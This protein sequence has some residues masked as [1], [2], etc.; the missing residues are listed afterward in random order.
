MTIRKAILATS[1][2][3]VAA[4]PIAAQE[5][6]LSHW[7]PAMHPLQRTGMEPW[8]ESIR[9]ATEGRVTIAIYPAQQLG[10]AVDHYDMARDGIADIVLINPGYQP[11]RFPV[12]SAGEL[13]FLIANAKGGSR[14]LHEWYLQYAGQEMG[15]TFPC[16]IMLHDPGTIHAMEGPLQ[17]PADVR[18][19]NVRPAHATLARM[20][21][22][23]GGASVQ[24]SPAEQSDL[25]S[26]GAADITA[27]PWGSLFTFGIEDIVT[28]HL[29]IPLYP[30]TFAFVINTAALEGLDPADQQVMRDHCTPEWSEKVASP[31]ADHEAGGRD[32]IIAMEGHTLYVP[33]EAEMAE[34]RA[35]AEPLTEEWKANVTAKGVDAEAAY[36]SFV[37]TL[38]RYGALAE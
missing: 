36:A 32:Q 24:V 35:V 14:A 31:W 25:L 28:H 18:G 27:S 15:D 23:L 7:V 3:C 5:L 12:L 4:Q 16:M 29:D 20:V 10:Q 38:D 11:G 2:L 33:T 8:A 6:T 1:L 13:P 34:W 30:T 22:L 17:T 9:Q 26:R 21:N 37:E 19:K